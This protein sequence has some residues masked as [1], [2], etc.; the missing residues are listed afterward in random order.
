MIKVRLFLEWMNSKEGRSNFL[1]NNSIE[2]YNGTKIIDNKKA[3]ILF[4]LKN[5]NGMDIEIIIKN[6]KNRDDEKRE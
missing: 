1:Y 3:P 2:M 6:I 4:G 5:A